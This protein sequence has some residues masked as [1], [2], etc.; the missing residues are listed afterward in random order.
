MKNLFYLQKNRSRL[1]AINT[2]KYCFYDDVPWATFTQKNI[3]VPKRDSIHLLT[4]ITTRIKTFT[5]ST[6]ALSNENVLYW[7]N[8]GSAIWVLI[9]QWLERLTGD[10][11]GCAGSSPALEVRYFLSKNSSKNIIIKTILCPS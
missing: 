3:W 7:Y 6:L 11:E 5:L 8:L 2:R 4:L 9:A 10:L 1:I